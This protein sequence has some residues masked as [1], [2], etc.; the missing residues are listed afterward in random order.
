M[1]VKTSGVIA[2]GFFLLS[3]LVGLIGGAG[4]PMILVRAIVFALFSFVL[5]EAIHLVAE[6]FLLD[7][8]AA[9]DKEMSPAGSHVDIAVE[10]DS[11]AE[12]S[13][14]AVIMDQAPASGAE[15]AKTAVKTAL[16]GSLIPDE[17]VLSSAL[18]ASGSLD[19]DAKS[20]FVAADGRG[21]AGGT[22]ADSE[23]A[24]SLPPAFGAMDTLFSNTAM[25][26]KDVKLPDMEHMTDSFV[27]KEEAELFEPPPR[28][29]SGKAVEAL[30][31][32]YDP[33]KAANAIKTLLQRE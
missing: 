21:V 15:S 17:G 33:A 27:E 22:G 29:H 5:S 2:G 13:D 6:R 8:P 14:A 3:F 25:P 10:D 30:G 20:P 26:L 16:A 1:H 12:A 31:K 18:P 7:S 4:F 23:A 32:N 28:R 24:D 9:T 19:M 11:G